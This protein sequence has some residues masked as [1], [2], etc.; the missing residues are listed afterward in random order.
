LSPIEKVTLTERV[1]QRLMEHIQGGRLQ[2]GDALPSQYQLARMFGVSRPVLR[3][4]MQGL[5]SIGL[6]EVRPGS[7]CYVGSPRILPDSEKL[8]EILTHQAALETLE[9]RMVV[10]VELAALAANRGDDH[11]WRT[12]ESILDRLRIASESGSETVAITSEF[13]EALSRSG[14]NAVLYKMS[15]LL[16]RARAAQGVR[17][18]QALPDITAGEYD[19]HLRLY[20]SV[21]SGSPSSARREMR[22]HLELAHGWEERVSALKI[23]IAA[24]PAADPQPH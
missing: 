2:P 8:F 20:M 15:H 16:S 18:E 1:A 12:I 17:I 5:V 14:H 24:A 23:Q 9:A 21:R 22:R 3:E 13:H 7:G 10:E 4:A 19:S 11:D 6:L